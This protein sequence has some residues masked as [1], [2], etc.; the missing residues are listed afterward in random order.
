MGRENFRNDQIYF[1]KL[2]YIFSLNKIMVDFYNK[3]PHFLGFK[4]QLLKGRNF[5]VA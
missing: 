3:V 2:S 5:L 1:I 4:C